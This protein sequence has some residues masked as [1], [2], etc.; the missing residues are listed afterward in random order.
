[1][2]GDEDVAEPIGHSERLAESIENA[3][4]KIVPNCG[5]LVPVESPASVL[6][7]LHQ[8]DLEDTK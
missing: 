5:H 7:V 6:E 2:V 4:L 1:M 3:Q 8:W